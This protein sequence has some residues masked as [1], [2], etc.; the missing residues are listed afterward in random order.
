MAGACMA[1][2]LFRAVRFDVVEQV[3]AD[4]VDVVVPR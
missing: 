1:I 3:P 4:P 2:L